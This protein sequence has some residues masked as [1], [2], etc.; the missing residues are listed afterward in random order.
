MSTRVHCRD[1]GWD[2]RFRHPATARR[3]A[4]RHRCPPPGNDSDRRPV[5]REA[6]HA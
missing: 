6:Q 4:T 5:T 3:A 1:C 2:E